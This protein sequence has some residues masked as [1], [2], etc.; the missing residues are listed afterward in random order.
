VVERI[1]VAGGLC[2]SFAIAAKLLGLLSDLPLSP[3]TVNETTLKIGQ[4]L[5]RQRDAHAAQHQARPLPAP[6]TVAHPPVEIAC[7]GVDGGRMQTR[8]PAQGPGVHQPH[9]RESKNAGFYRMTGER[10]A[11]DP[12]PEL[13][14][15]FSSRKQLQGLLAGLEETAGSQ[16]EEAPKPDFSWRPKSH[17]RTCLASLCAS[18]QFAGLMAAEAER[19]GFFAAPRK[20]FLGD[21]LPYN[22]TIHQTCFGAFVPILDF[23]HPVERLHE[24]S[25][26]L[27][28]HG[29]QAWEHCQKWMALCWQGDV[30]EVLGLLQAEQHAR[31][32]PEDSTPEGDARRVLA[33]TI[34]YLR[35]NASRMDYPRYRTEGLPITSCLIESQIKEMNYRV[36]GSEKFWNDGPEGEAILQV[37]AALIGD[38]DRL[39][40][41]L[42]A[43]PGSPFARPSRK[44]SP[45]PVT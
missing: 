10:Y 2:K 6:P 14:S 33:E 16:A 3:R 11:E 9:W 38:D 41:H 31:G 20:A 24:T 1:V 22:W 28:D 32:E 18:N 43:R 44:H 35:N 27:W 8:T 45:T 7:I 23:I 26:A 29:P 40:R 36:K 42:A 13:P 17:F 37:R 34:G 21:G 4:E 15:C 19:R 12:H 30:E 39:S 25:R 5:E